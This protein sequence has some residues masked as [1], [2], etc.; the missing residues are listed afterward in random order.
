[1]GKVAAMRWYATLVSL[2]MIPTGGFPT[3]TQAKTGAAAAGAPATIYSGPP[4]SAIAYGTPGCGRLTGGVQLPCAG[5]NFRA[6]SPLVCVL[7]RN[8]VHPAVQELVL[9]SYADL[10]AQGTLQRWIYGDTGFEFGGEFWPHHTHQHG[11]SVDFFFPVRMTASAD[12]GADTQSDEVTPAFLPTDL[13]TGLGYAID[14]SNSG[15]FEELSMDWH[16]IAEHLISLQRLATAR[17][18]TIRRIILAPPL[19]DRLL[20]MAP[21]AKTVAHLFSQRQAWFR[22]DEHYHVDFELP[23]RFRRPHHCERQAAAPSMRSSHLKSAED[24]SSSTLDTGR[25]TAEATRW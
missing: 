4:G 2:T 15:R 19:R 3:R 17:G 22:H 9:A 25:T 11:L 18:M 8:Y 24:L 1:M 5:S 14:F 21:Q 20:R 13:F 6:T 23:R 16:A 7:G 10:E 12:D